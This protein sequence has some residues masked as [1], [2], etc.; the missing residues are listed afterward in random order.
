M[1]PCCGLGATHPAELA[2]LNGQEMMKLGFLPICLPSSR[3]S[4]QYRT[5]FILK[6]ISL[7]DLFFFLVWGSPPNRSCQAAMPESVAKNCGGYSSATR[8]CA[9]TYRSPEPKHFDRKRR[10]SLCFPFTHPPPRHQK[11]PSL[12]L[13]SVRSQG[14]PVAL[15]TEAGKT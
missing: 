3:Q 8:S 1:L 4:S 12:N 14:M 13:G 9:R 11:E 10:V 6:G 7:C 2:H 5:P 15:Q